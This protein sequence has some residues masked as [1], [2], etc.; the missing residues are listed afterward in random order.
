MWLKNAENMRIKFTFMFYKRKT[1]FI[2]GNHVRVLMAGF[3]LHQKLY[4]L[5]TEENFS[6]PQIK[7]FIFAS[8]NIVF[9]S[10]KA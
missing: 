7:N 5:F 2:K 8:Q 4:C 10:W 1:K 3:E 9:Y 6:L